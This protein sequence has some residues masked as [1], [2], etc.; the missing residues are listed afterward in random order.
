MRWDVVPGSPR[1]IVSTPSAISD[2]P[3]AT[4][5]GVA[6]HPRRPGRYRITLADGRQWL[7][8]AAAL[9]EAGATRPGVT[10]APGQV[11]VLEREAAIIG[12]LD[13]AVASLARRR[14]SRRELERAAQRRGEDPALV[15]LA[16]ERL[17]DAGVLDDQVL[18]EAEAASGLRR[19]EAPARVR[20]RLRRR[21]VAGTGAEE[22]IRRAVQEEQYDE[23]GACEALARKRWPALAPLAPEVR[24]RRLVGFLLRRGFGAAT[25]QRVV[26]AL[27]REG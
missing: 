21:G 9:A 26:R 11:A 16:L 25:V 13:R 19:G 4:V 8:S 20:Q 3:P 18:A 24:R 12:I 10:L 27:E 14:R 15:R 1:L 17:A 7:V 23:G 6:E 2:A 5:K 22:A